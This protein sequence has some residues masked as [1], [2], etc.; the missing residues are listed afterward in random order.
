VWRYRYASGNNFV[1]IRAVPAY[2]K[3]VSSLSNL[4]RTWFA[5]RVIPILFAS[6][7]TA[8]ALTLD[9]NS[10]GISDATKR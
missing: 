1:F 5:M 2:F 8:I 7:W 9:V 3:I 4:S 10:S 6:A